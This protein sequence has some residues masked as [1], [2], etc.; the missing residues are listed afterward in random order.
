MEMAW[1]AQRQDPRQPPENQLTCSIPRT[2][3]R[4]G[5][6][7]EK[8]TDRSCSPLQQQI[9]V[10]LA[11]PAQQQ[12]RDDTGTEDCETPQLIVNMAMESAHV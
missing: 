7:W 5:R 6:A 11:V 4:L 1:E 12:R 3:E 9:D 8:G 10:T 2:A